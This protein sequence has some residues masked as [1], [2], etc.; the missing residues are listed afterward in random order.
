MM[1]KRINIKIYF[2]C[3]WLFSVFLSSHF[4]SGVPNETFRDQLHTLMVLSTYG[5]MYQGPAIV[6]YWLLRRWRNVAVGFSVFLA[7]LGH[8]L[9][10]VDSH[11]HDLYG[12]HINGFVWNLL[13]SPGG[14]DS[15]G[16]DQTNVFVAL[17][18]VSVLAVVHIGGLT[19]GTKLP[20]FHIPVIKVLILLS[21]VTFAE[22]GVYAYSKAE[23]YGP[24]LDRGDAVFLYQT[25]SINSFLKTMGIKVER[26][27]QVSVSQDESRQLNYPK[28]PIST[29]KVKKPFN[30]VML[31]SESMR[32]DLLSPTVM[33]NMSAFAEKAWNFKK[34]YSGGNGTR[35]GLFALFYGLQ[36]NYWDVFLRNQQG[37]VLFDVLNE[38]KY[39][40]FIYT[41][42]KFSYPEFDRTIFSAIPPEK[43]IE[44]NKGEPWQRDQNNTTALIDAIQTRDHSRPFYGFLFYEATHA[45][46]SFPDNAIVRKD[47][48]QTLDYAGL[49][50]KEL[51]PQ[52]KG[53]KARYENAAYGID[54]QLQRIVES[55][56]NSGDIENTLLIIT[57]DHGEEFMERGR[58]GHN[59]AFTDWQVRVPMIMWMPGSSA[60]IITQRTSH[61]D[62]PTTILDR[63][64]IDNPT[65]D[66]NL[67][68][69]L[70]SPLD[71][72]N[73]VVASWSDIGLINNFG[74]LVIPFKST[75]QHSN[76]T[77]GLDDKAVDGKTLLSQMQPEIL[78]ALSNARYYYNKE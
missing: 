27:A 61:I 58:W 45:R 70:S 47:Y 48:L 12:F 38:Y 36:G 34:H 73:M 32:W 30:I 3:T 74:K 60:K 5:A 41:S 69:D 44:N 66:Y 33:P 59:S 77:M 56:E 4:L 2:L 65:K 10:F 50:R 51:A 11:L 23:L 16:A 9:V 13:T 21:L 14:F 64:G 29:S 63:L 49:S 46:Y 17:G 22:R 28:A 71:N 20:R 76:L 55:L 72:R 75:T 31:I 25:T 40:Y 43:L 24:V 8:V 39:Q 52:I 42:A 62:V 26:V 78:K 6:S 67:G 15:L 1:S 57:G 53:M 18:Y 7:I 19:A 37:P 68:I 35:Q 54:I